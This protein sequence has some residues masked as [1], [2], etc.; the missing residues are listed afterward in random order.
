MFV[1]DSLLHLCAQCG[2]SKAGIF[3]AKHGA[4]VN[5]TNSKV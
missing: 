5:L 1:G 3:L 4:K 2:N